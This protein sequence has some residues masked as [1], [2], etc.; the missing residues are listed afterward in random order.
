MYSETRSWRLLWIVSAAPVRVHHTHLGL[1]ELELVH[2]LTGVPVDESLAAVHGRELL[3]DT[4]E[5]R[6]DR[7]RVADEGRR[8]L[9]ATGRNVTLSGGNVS[10]DPLDEVGRVLGLDGLELVLD[11]LH[12]NLTAVDAHDG[13]VAAVTGVRSSHH[14][15]GVEHLLSELRN[16]DSAVRSRATR[17]EGR[18]ADHEEVETG[19]GN[20]VD[21]ELAEVRVELTGETETGGDTGHDNRDEVVEVTVGGGGELEG[22][23][24][25]VVES[26]VV[27]TE[28]LVRVLNKLVDREGGVVGLND[29][30][31]DLGRGDDREGAHHAVGV[32]L[33]NLGDEEGTHTGTGTTTERVGDL[34]ALEAVTALSLTTD[35]VENRVDELGT[36]SV[37]ALGP[38][39]TGTRLT[40]DKVVGAEERAKGATTDRVHGSGLEVDKDGTGHVLASSRLIVVDVDA[41]ELNVRGALVRAVG[42]DAVLLRDDLPVV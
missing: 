18:K 22:T 17:G 39:V 23:E 5:E 11:L 25:D 21:G 19:E 32:L 34:E 15:L 16:R 42:L 4:L 30:V 3:A 40:E 12:R 29:S 28:G 9:E 36:L 31:G 33:T 14:V 26:L 20:H 38:V 10:G 13:E 2:A 37:V 24:A 1:G 41:L 8:H 6:L 35:N 27:D 7:G